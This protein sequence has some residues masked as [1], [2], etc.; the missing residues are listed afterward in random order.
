MSAASFISVACRR[1][2]LSQRKLGHYWPL[3]ASAHFVRRR[4]LEGGTDQVVNRVRLTIVQLERQKPCCQR[5]RDLSLAAAVYQSAMRRWVPSSGLHRPNNLVK[6]AFIRNQGGAN[7]ICTRRPRSAEARDGFVRQDPQA[8]TPAQRSG[9]WSRH[10]APVVHPSVCLPN[11][12][13]P[14]S[15]PLSGS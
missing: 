15:S 7:A 1:Q 13:W 3:R 10:K 6:R 5:C 14:R 12:L 9:R 4:P 2:A 11:I 8:E